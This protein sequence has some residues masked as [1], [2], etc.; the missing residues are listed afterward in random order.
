MLN[1][2]KRQM[3][4]KMTGLEARLEAMDKHHQE[5]KSHVESKLA[6][7]LLDLNMKRDVARELASQNIEFENRLI[8]LEAEHS[9]TVADR[10]RLANELNSLRESSSQELDRLRLHYEQKLYILNQETGKE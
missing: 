7:A 3:T 1:D 2:T 6:S 8:Y 5:Y 10:D 4:D 9:N